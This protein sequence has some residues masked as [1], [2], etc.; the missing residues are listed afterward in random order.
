MYEIRDPVHSTIE[1][2]EKEKTVID[3]PCVQRLRFIRQLGMTF[4]VYP[5]AEHDRFSHAVGAM[6]VA[7]RVWKRIEETSGDLLK[8]YFNGRELAYFREILRLAAL[9]H[10]VGHPPFSHVSEKFMPRLSKLAL[11]WTWFKDINKNRQATH[12][13]YSV[14]LI[15]KLC[16]GNGAIFSKEQAQDIASLVHHEV[17]PSKKWDK[18]FGNGVGRRGIHA[19]LRSLISGELD[20]DRMDYLLRDGHYTGVTYGFFDIDHIIQNL[21]VTINSKKE[22]VLTLDSTAVRAFEDFLLARYHMFL[23]VYLHKTTLS[24]DYFLEK[25]LADGELT[26]EFSGHADGYLD[27]RDSTLIEKL[28]ESSKA[29]QGGWSFK[30]LSR[31]PGKLILSASHA[32]GKRLIRRLE[33]KFKKAGIKFF[34][35]EAKQYLSKLRS[36]KRNNKSS[37]LVRRKM[38]GKVFYEPIAKYSSLL[39]RYNEIIDIKNLYVMPDQVSKV[40]KIMAN[41][42]IKRP[43]IF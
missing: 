3:H 1:F 13:D 30:L 26:L 6:H 32:N 2:N 40:R 43:S 36:E 8:E 4:L 34:T 20:V 27:L 25:A 22:L 17:S 16:L 21:G 42:A 15:S 9:L 14:L 18:L 33:K 31:K 37:F 19:L 39:N 24:F 23:Q 41:I 5:G 38:L 12:E 28:F 11:P 7:G 29:V 10:D 35:V